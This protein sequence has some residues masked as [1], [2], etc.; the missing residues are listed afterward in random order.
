MGLRELR[1][2]VP[3]RRI[4]VNAWK[5]ESTLTG[6]AALWDAGSRNLGHARRRWLRLLAASNVADDDPI[7]TEDSEILGEPSGDEV[8]LGLKC[9]CAAC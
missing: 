2:A 5:L 4:K 3:D 6:C 9:G 8:G 1:S 7:R